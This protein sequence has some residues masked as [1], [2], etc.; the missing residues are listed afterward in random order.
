[1][2]NGWDV[3]FAVASLSIITIYFLALVRVLHRLGFSGWWSIVSV[4]PIVNICA[5]LA[6]SFAR[7]P[8]TRPN[9]A[10][11]SMLEETLSRI[12]AL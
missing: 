8:V 9:A 3:F 12:K 6:L 2:D 10:A 1:M 4:I 11:V 7:W 5:L